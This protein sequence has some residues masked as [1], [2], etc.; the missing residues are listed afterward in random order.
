M[1]RQMEGLLSGIR[2]TDFTWAQAG[3]FASE[4]LTLMGAEVIKIENRKHPDIL[5]K[6]SSALGF[7]E[8]EEEDLDRSVEFNFGNLNKLSL[9]L[10]LRRKKGLDIARQ[11]IARS[12]VVLENFSPGVMGRL[13][14]GYE[15]VREI[16]PDIIML[17]ISYSGQAGPESG[18]LGY[19][20][21][22][23]AASG[24]SYLTGYP[25]GPPG[26]IRLPIDSNVGATAAVSLLAAL[27]RR[28]R[29]GE[30]QYIDVSARESMSCLMGHSFIEA[31][32]GR[33]PERRGNLDEKM[34]PHECYPCKGDENWISI[35][36]EGEQEWSALCEALGD[37]ALAADPRFA[38]HD[39]R[40]Q[41]RAELDRAIS[42]HT[43]K[44]DASE[45]TGKLQ[46]AGV[47]SFPALRAPDVFD[48]AHL[49]SREFIT[50]VD[51]PKMGEQ[52]V[53][54]PAWKFSEA[55]P[56]ITAPAPLM[57]EHNSYVLKDL[58][59]MTEEQIKDLEEEGVIC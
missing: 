3:P 45:L 53:F 12:D 16:K 48:D 23:Y 36:I 11:L 18:Y 54:A 42:N 27:W 9:G 8:G 4:V 5:R 58:L 56:Q 21:L 24:L 20:S 30:G 2:V 14:L 49:L 59:G 6:L 44:F 17:S 37:E 31:S 15:V 51:H 34:L 28:Q 39:E 7:A 43:V 29:T 50:S 38:S 57:G 25:D 35:A 41:H 26:Y 40:L 52:R 47:A 32:L 19:A 46:A 55:P 13:G 10:D 1:E 33:S 22:F